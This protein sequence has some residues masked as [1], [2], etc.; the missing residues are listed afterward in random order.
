MTGVAT[1]AILDIEL[2]AGYGLWRMAYGILWGAWG[3]GDYETFVAYISHFNMFRCK[4]EP[5]CLSTQWW[6][7]QVSNVRFVSISSG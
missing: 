4:G 6:K 3:D 7:L 5:S 2:T 1:T